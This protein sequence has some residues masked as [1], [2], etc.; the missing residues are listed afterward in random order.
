MVVALLSDIHSNIVALEAVCEDLEKQGIEKVAILGDVVGYG[1]RTK[2]TLLKT[3][4]LVGKGA[5]ILP[6]N[7]DQI[8]VIKASSMMNG[9]VLDSTRSIGEKANK[10]LDT[11]VE[12]ILTKNPKH[13]LSEDFVSELYGRQSEYSPSFFEALHEGLRNKRKE[14]IGWLDY[15]LPGFIAI[16]KVMKGDE[17][18]AKN[19]A[20]GIWMKEHPKMYG[21]NRESARKVLD[22]EEAIEAYRFLEEFSKYRGHLI[23]EGV[24]CFHSTSWD[25]DHPHYYL[26][27]PH[28]AEMFKAGGFDLA[29]MPVFGLRKAFEL[30]QILY[31]KKIEVAL[32]HLHVPSV[33]SAEDNGVEL[34]VANAGTVGMPRLE[35]FGGET[36][37]DKATYLVKDG[38]DF[39]IRLVEYNWE[40][41]YEDMKEVGLPMNQVWAKLKGE[42]PNE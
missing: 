20:V 41:V 12:Q 39:A 5:K 8:F 23:F 42:W 7:H 26:A 2:E 38:S 6:G 18:F 33:Y 4:E 40:K 22:R 27:D 36:Y 24:H 34:T 37:Y 31:K 14:G 30:A 15:L 11:Q 10:A 19:D 28:Q 13:F 17:S 1:P 9:A 16:R 29:G 25:K 3:K 21:M 35:K 32:G